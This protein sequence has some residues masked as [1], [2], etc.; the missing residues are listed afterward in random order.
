MRLEED[1]PFDIIRLIEVEC[2]HDEDRILVSVSFPQ[3][4]FSSTKIRYYCQKCDI[5]YFQFF[6]KY[7]TDGKKYLWGNQ[8]K[9]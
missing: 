4:K 5:T 7:E 2:N 8:L 1:K 6:W 3:N 9:E